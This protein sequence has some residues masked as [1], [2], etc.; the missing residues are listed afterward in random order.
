MEGYSNDAIPSSANYSANSPNVNEV[1]NCVNEGAAES[2][3]PPSDPSM[4]KPPVA[5]SSKRSRNL[6]SSVWEH[7]TQI[8]GGEN[9]SSCN[10]CKHEL[11]AG[12]RS[13]TTSMRNH[14]ASCPKENS[15]D[16]V[17][18]LKKQKQLSLT[19]NN[20]GKVRFG[21][22]TFDQEVSRKELASSI[23]M[24][25]YPLSMVDHIGFR[26][27]VSS[28]Q[29][30]FKMVS[31]N[32]IKD[33]VLR[34]YGSE[35]E[36][37][38][39]V[40]DKLKSRIAITTD[41]WTSNQKKGYMSITAHYIDELWVLQSRVLSFI[42]MPT[43]HTMDVL[44]S[45]LMDA[46]TSWNIETKVSTITVDNCYSNDVVKDGLSI[47]ENSIE[48]IR[49][50]VAYWSASPSRVE[51]FED[52]AR[53][54]KIPFSRKLCLDCKTC[55]NSTF[56]M[57][58]TTI[59]YKDVFPRL[60]LRDKNYSHLPSDYD[61][62]MAEIIAEKLEVF[63][64]A[65]KLFSG[66]N[67]PTSNCFFVQ[68]GLLRT[69]LVKWCNDDDLFIKSMAT[70]MFEKFE[71][72]SRHSRTSSS[73][74]SKVTVSNVPTSQQEDFSKL[75]AFL[76]ESSTNS[77]TVNSELD[78]YLEEATLPWSQDFDILNWWKTLGIRYPTL[79]KIAK[80]ILAIPVSTVASES[81]FSTSGRV[82]SP[83]R[84]RLHPNTL[85]AL[86]CSQNWLWNSN[87]NEGSP[88]NL[89]ASS[90]CLCITEE[91]VGESN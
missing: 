61:W 35:K 24:H 25:E 41:L 54:M 36:R 3:P 81:A 23:I 70:K 5:P 18:C 26:K 31:R 73:S 22:F 29:P 83:H 15:Q 30:L 66:R 62:S 28:L 84:S 85:E 47:I 67:Y 2:V 63:Y 72:N 40:F 55:W 78:H 39:I 17:E 1:V 11:K 46:L 74:S 14:L 87:E 80:D 53:Q 16:I 59:L 91:D 58:K 71:N 68:I 86:M 48:R 75:V 34:I 77:S 32:T 42:Y 49:S 21:N 69:S 56:L 45:N 82:V 60:Q 64:N 19:T 13:G 90:Y 7:F 38:Q 88:P 43:P 44:A 79:Q 51:K 4:S 57:L 76:N 8:G 52:M 9:R 37:M 33:D 10:Y 27:F 12:G 50:S 65:T 89:D 20:D 6:T